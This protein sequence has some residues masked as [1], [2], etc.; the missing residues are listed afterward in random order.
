[1]KL[2]LLRKMIPDK[3]VIGGRD[4]DAVKLGLNDEEEF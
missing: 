1:M 4:K 2:M 3:K